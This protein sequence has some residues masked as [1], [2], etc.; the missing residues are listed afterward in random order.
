MMRRGLLALPLVVLA[1]VP[2]ACGGGSDEGP[3]NIERGR[4]LFT[5]GGREG[6]QL[7]CGF[8]HTLHATKTQGA[9]GPSLDQEGGEYVAQK[10]TEAQK[11]EFVLKWIKEGNCLDPREPSR[12]MPGGLFSGSDAKAVAAFVALC[13]GHPKAAGC[14]PRSGGLTGQAAK[15]EKYFGSNGCVGCHWATEGN[16]P[17]G[18]SFYGLPGSKVEL[19]DGRTVTADDA[20][21]IRS[22][23][24][25]EA[26]L[27]KGYAPGSMSGRVPK[28]L[29]TED[30]AKAIVAYMKTLEGNKTS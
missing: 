12:C 13:A 2:A 29:I 8:C 26:D 18:P 23:V 6:R 9:Y 19:A 5:T 1:L 7:S 24:D 14:K 22:I 27:V 28:G 4:A 30:Q 16:D 20:Y 21:L 11:R 3:P 17:V 15:G 10:K 25:P